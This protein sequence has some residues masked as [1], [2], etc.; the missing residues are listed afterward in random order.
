MAQKKSQRS[1]NL[2][3]ISAMLKP[4]TFESKTYIDFA[5][6]KRE[7]LIKWALSHMYLFFSFM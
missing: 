1:L 2:S 6:K 3:K 4:K 5:S 7:K